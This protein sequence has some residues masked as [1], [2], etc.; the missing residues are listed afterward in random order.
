MVRFIFRFF[1]AAAFALSAQFAMAQ[2]TGQVAPT[3]AQILSQYH[4][5]G[6]QMVKQVSDLVSSDKTTIPAILEFA[7][8]ADEDQR[9]AIAEGLAQVAKANAQNDP[10]FA[11]QIQQAVAASGIP[12][13]A[14]AYAEAA[15]DTGTA[16]IG[17]GG[18]GGGPSGPG[19]PSGGPNTG[20]FPSGNTFTQNNTPNLL[21]GQTLGGSSSSQ[22]S[23]F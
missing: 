11:N 21:T 5:G 22:V 7:K 17:G 15:G 16:S 14:K 10:G 4:D 13:L 9:K 3:P 2:G 1:I 6:P 12:E 20:G 8:T 23:G 18:G 19:A